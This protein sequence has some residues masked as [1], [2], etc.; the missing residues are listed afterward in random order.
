[1]KKVVSYFFSEYNFSNQAL[2]FKQLL[3]LFLSIKAIYWLCYYDLYFGQNAIAYSKTYSLGVLKDIAFLLYNNKATSSGYYFITGIFVSLLLSYFIKKIPFLFEFI[4]W[5]LVINIH[6]KIYSTLTGGDYL[7]NQFLFFNCFI[8]KPYTTNLSWQSS[9]SRF[10]HNFGVLAIIIQIQLVYV[11]AAIAK[12]Y[13]TDWINGLAII[14]LDPVE[15]Y[16]MF[17]NLHLT[18]N[19]VGYIINYLVLLY[20]LL[21]PVLIWIN[22]FKKPFLVIGILT[23]LY[24]AFVIGIVGFG[25][26]MLFA[27]IFFWPNKKTLNNFH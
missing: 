26:I 25:L 7:L 2:R 20:Q 24:I 12:L 10:F 5:L 16:H 15:H 9:L 22:K 1:M 27:Y 18:N 17:C 11:V 21:F 13:S 4:I 6:N 23:H 3:Y 8:S 14:K 19:F